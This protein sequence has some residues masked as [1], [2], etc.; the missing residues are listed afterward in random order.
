MKL[1]LF[2]QGLAKLILTGTEKSNVLVFTKNKVRLAV[3]AYVSLL[4]LIR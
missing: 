4:V 3:L 2:G 1:A